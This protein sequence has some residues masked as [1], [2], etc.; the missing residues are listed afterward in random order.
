M[1]KA[2][3]AFIVVQMLYFYFKY[4]LKYVNY[5]NFTEQ[6]YESTTNI[7]LKIDAE[8]TCELPGTFEEK[9]P[10]YSGPIARKRTNQVF[11]Q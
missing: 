4:S 11:R 5:S 1:D 2:I 6:L 10:K 8:I 3:M 9:E 7:I